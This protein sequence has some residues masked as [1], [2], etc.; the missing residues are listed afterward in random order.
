MN[1][2]NLKYL[3]FYSFSFIA[4][5]IKQ[6]LW[7]ETTPLPLVFHSNCHVNLQHPSCLEDAPAKDHQ[8]M[9]DLHQPS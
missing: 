2:Y 4:L 1:D 9:P 3:L 5:K 8:N 6:S 7:E